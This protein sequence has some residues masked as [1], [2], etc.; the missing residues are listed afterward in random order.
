MKLS[1]DTSALKSKKC[2]PS[3]GKFRGSQ[4]IW[5]QVF[6]NLDQKNLYTH[7]LKNMVKENIVWVKGW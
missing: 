3:F 4:I 2:N 5:L 1:E 7:C 6:Q